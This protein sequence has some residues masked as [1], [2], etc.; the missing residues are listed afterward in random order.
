ILPRRDSGLRSL[1]VLLPILC[2]LVLALGDRQAHAADDP[3]APKK[4]LSFAADIAPLL[5]ARCGKCH[6]GTE[7]KGGLRLSSRR[8][9]LKGGDSGPAIRIAAAESSLIWEKLAANEMPAGG[10]PL[11]AEEKGR[12]RSWINDGAL[13]DEPADPATDATP[14]AASAP[15]GVSDHWSFRPP[16]RPVPPLVSAT[17]QMRTPVDAFILVELESRELALSPV[18]ERAA[19]LR[20]AAFDLTGLPPTPEEV[21][22]FLS[23]PSADAWERQIDR[24]LAS[25]RYGE[26]WGRHW[27]DL[28]G[29]AD[30]AGVLAED[31]PLP[32]AFR[33]RDY[34]VQAFNSNKP[35]DR[36]LQEQIAGDELTGYW[37]AYATLDRLPE[38]VLEGVIATGYLRCAPDSSRPDF[39]TIKNADAQYFYPTLNDTLQIVASSTLGLTLQCAR[40][41]T[42]KYDPIPQTEYY[43]LQ[44]IFMAALR[45]SQWIPQME[46]RILVATASQKRDGDEHNARLDAEIA[47][48]KA[49]LAELLKQNRDKLVAERLA[50]LPESIRAD[51]Q[52]AVTK[53]AAQRG[54]IEKYLAD[55]FTPLLNPDAATLAK[56]L[57]E[58]YP[59][60]RKAVE[61]QNAEIAAQ[62][63]QR[64]H[65]DEL[66]ALYDLPGP[67][68]TPVLRRGDA[69]TPGQPVEPGVVSALAT[70]LPFAWQPPLAE[71]PTS[72]RRLAFARW[73]T[74]PEHPLTARVFVNRVWLH[75]FG[76]GLVTTP[77]DF[78]TIGA[79]P[80]HPQL[81]DWLATE[82]VESGWDIKRLH[83]LIM[84]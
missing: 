83:R 21:R 80:T 30:S 34:V 17:D 5:Q 44:A 72:G 66:R 39:S 8:E 26:R 84:N 73:L 18:A 70:P 81:L 54:E 23:D 16:V 49:I 15:A 25:P 38:E 41:H 31:R 36:F 12:I 35:Y 51:V 74:Q 63:R 46:R 53:E 11:S 52:A 82:F 59:E 40:C 61:E 62:E 14:A 45:P 20:R 75:H 22:E 58:T 79:L 64:R 43:R 28:A 7:P 55:K 19:L 9:L 27:L 56:V 24:L 13:A 37:N 6:S 2:A 67:V 77:E 10:P 29:Y 68:T 1:I 48:R 71:A 42:H 65:Y 50:T 76:E 3:S 69:L 78:G 57:P 33:Y 60:Y 32:T 4:P 47:R